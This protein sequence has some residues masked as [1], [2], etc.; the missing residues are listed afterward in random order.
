MTA[1]Q[2]RAHL[3][4]AVKRPIRRLVDAVMITDTVHLLHIGKTGGT[5]LKHALGE[6]D[7]GPRRRIVLHPHGVR[8]AD[9]PTGD[10]VVFVVRDPVDRFVS[11]F[12]SRQRQGRPRYHSAWRGVEEAAFGRFDS[13]E[14]LALG[15]L[16]EATRPM[17]VEAMNGIRH[18]GDRLTDVL[19]SCDELRARQDDIV[20]AGRLERLD[21]DLGAL[22]RALGVD[23]VA[24]P[25]DPVQAHRS[26]APPPSLSRAAVES[27]RNWY[28]DD[29]AILDEVDRLRLGRGL[30]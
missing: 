26:P 25:S 8:L 28:A 4:V 20:F 24:L 10:G 22:A 18:V 17:A 14:S 21:E 3:P 19:G 30:R 29:Q 6:L 16:D 27:L 13:P 1:V 23:E 11:G 15:L 2:V 5:A 9:I 12:L 7:L